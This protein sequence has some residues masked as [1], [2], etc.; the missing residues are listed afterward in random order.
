HVRRMEIEFFH[1]DSLRPVLLD[2]VGIVIAHLPVG[3]Y[4]GDEWAQHFQLEAEEGHTCSHH[5]LLERRMRYERG[6]GHRLFHIPDFLFTSDQSDQLQA[7]LQEHAH[8]VGLLELPKTVFKD[9]SHA[10]SIFILQKKGEH[11]SACKQP[12]LVQLPSLS[13]AQAMEDILGQM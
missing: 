5:L 7:Y 3:Y 2:S 13:N 10:K 9:D 11:T 12:L 1:Q 8:I 6:G 4:P